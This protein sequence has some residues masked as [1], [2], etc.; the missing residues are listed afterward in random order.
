MQACYSCLF[1]LLLL[2]TL[3]TS[4]QRAGQFQLH[5]SKLFLKYMEP[6]ARKSYLKVL[7]D[8]QS[9]WQYPVLI[10]RPPGSLLQQ[11]EIITKI[12]NWPKCTMGCPTPND[13]STIQPLHLRLRDNH[14]GKMRKII[15]AREPEFLPQDSILDMTGMLVPMESSHYSCL[16][17]AYVTSPENMP[18]KKGELIKA[19]LLD[20]FQALSGC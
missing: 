19:P 11:I 16:N 10:W 5:F 17:K 13:N 2:N 15:K 18:T 4:Y 1:Y 14:G 20:E 7:G 6:S 12:H 3:R 8:D 9:Q